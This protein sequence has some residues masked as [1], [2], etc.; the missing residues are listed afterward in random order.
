MENV[1]VIGPT[2]VG[3]TA[4]FRHLIRSKDVQGSIIKEANFFLED[5]Y[6][7]R[8]YTSIFRPDAGSSK[9]RL[10]ASPKYFGASSVVAERIARTLPEAQIVFILRD[11]V[12]RFLSIIDHILV[13]RSPG[14]YDCAEQ[15]IST[16]LKNVVEYSATELDQYAMLESFYVPHISEFSK[17]FDK[18]QIHCLYYE[19][20]FFGSGLE[21][22]A[23]FLGINDLAPVIQKENAGRQVKNT[24][25]HKYFLRL[26]N[27]LEPVLNKSPMIRSVLRRV[28]YF[29]L[30]KSSASTAERCPDEVASMIVDGNRGLGEVLSRKCIVHSKVEPDWVV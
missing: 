3:T 6:L 15:L 5:D 22:F 9:W 26:N 7:D 21:S 24:S 18:E 28:Y 12:E 1:I 4:L 10:E 2:R 23:R 27:R 25:S 16:Q 13:K 14:K 17:H 30:E 29:F 19:D 20:L 8:K 11:P